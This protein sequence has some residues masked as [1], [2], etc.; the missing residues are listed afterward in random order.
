MLQEV[1][2][3][4]K[5]SGSGLPGGEISNRPLRFY[6]VADVSG[7]MA[8]SKI[9]ELNFAVREALPAMVSVAEENANIAVQVRALQFGTGTKWITDAP[10]PLDQYAWRDL[11]ITGIT[12]MGAAMREMARELSVDNMPDR[13][14][15][16]VIIL[17]SDGQPTD[18]FKGGL[19]ELMREP[20]GQRAVRISIAIGESADLDV[21][22]QFI[23]HSEIKPLVA[24]NSADLVNYIRWVSTAVLQTASAPASQST[25]STT[26]TP[27]AMG[28]IAD[29]TPPQPIDNPADTEVW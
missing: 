27:T 14:V 15:P 16:P 1:D 11:S 4:E 25:T 3:T 17:L 10:V 12:D 18:D 24:N 8:G 2:Q 5:A 21:L 7:S 20:W 9:G 26:E 29:L 22:Q 23:G 13:S 6:W 19:A 28:N